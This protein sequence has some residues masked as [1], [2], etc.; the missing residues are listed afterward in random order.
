MQNMS[1]C[2]FAKNGKDGLG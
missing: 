2:G 1:L